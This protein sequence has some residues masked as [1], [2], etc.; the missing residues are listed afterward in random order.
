MADL[1]L[2]SASPRRQELIRTFGIPYQI[3]PVDADETTSC[4]IAERVVALARRKAMR[5]S[6]ILKDPLLCTEAEMKYRNSIR[7]ADEKVCIL[8][9]DTLVGRGEDILGKPA[10]L[11]QAREM[12]RLLQDSWHEVLSGICLTEMHSGETFTHCEITRVHF[13]PMTDRD[14][15]Y[16][17]SL[18]N[19]LDKAG[20]YGIQ[21]GA[22]LFI[23]RIEGCYY[24]VVGFPLSAVRSMLSRYFVF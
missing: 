21:S 22:G 19:P 23:D 18:D 5:A 16:Y 2:A 24:N 17:F 20:A 14:I 11:A 10:D 15:D 8:G 1:I 9:V 12:L 7:L 13:T 6:A 4:P 3:L